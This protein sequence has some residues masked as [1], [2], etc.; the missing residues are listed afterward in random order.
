[1]YD[2]TKSKYKQL[3]QIRNTNISEVEPSESE[4]LDKWKY[5]KKRMM[6]LRLT[7]GVQD[8]IGIEYT[9]ISWLNV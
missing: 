4:K 1:M 7:D 8:I 6:Q 9:Q 5:P 2:I 3:E